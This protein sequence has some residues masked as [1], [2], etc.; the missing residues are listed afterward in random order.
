MTDQTEKKKMS[1]GCMIGLIVGGVFVAMVA[2]AAIT[3][4]MKKDDIARYGISALLESI[5]ISVQAGEI[6]GVDAERFT[7]MVDAFKVKLEAEPLDYAKFQRFAQSIQSMAD[8][9][10]TSKE[11]IDA[12]MEAM[13]EYF[14][15]LEQYSPPDESA[16]STMADDSTAVFDS[17]AAQ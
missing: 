2:V 5:K 4:Y 15:E 8:G 16:G 13:V 6:E 3:C 1:K 9:E 10:G 7:Q 11:E 12:L 14:P 17:T